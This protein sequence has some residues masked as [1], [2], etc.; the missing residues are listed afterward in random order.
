VVF[1]PYEIGTHDDSAILVLETLRGVD[2]ADLSEPGW[3]GGPQ[4]LGLA[5]SREVVCAQNTQL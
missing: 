5:F 1:A 2:A 4:R 3:V